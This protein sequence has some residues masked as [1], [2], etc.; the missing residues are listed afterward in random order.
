VTGSTFGWTAVPS[1]PTLSGFS[2]GNGN[3]IAQTLTNTGFTIETV[4]YTIIPSA[5]ACDGPPGNFVVTVNP[6]PDLSNDPASSQICSATSPEVILTSH[7]A[8]ATFTW[9]A[10][11]SSANITGY[12]PGSGLVIDQVLT[13][14]G[15]NV[16]TVT[17][18][19][20][21]TANGCPGIAKDY[22]VTI[23]SVPDVYFNPPAQAICNAETCNIQNL[24]T[25]TGTT[26]TWT[27][28]GSSAN[29]SGFSAGSGNLIAQ[30]LYNSGTTTET[31]TYSVA[32]TAFGC[33]A[34]P[35]QNLVVT[36][37]PKPAITSSVT[38]FSQC[39][40][41]TTGIV[42]AAGVANSTF[43]WVAGG[44]SPQVTGYAD[45]AGLIIQ[46]TLTNSGF[47][48][49]LV[50]YSVTPVANSCNGDPVDFTVTVYPVADVYFTPDGQTLCTGMT[51]NMTIAS[52]VAG[53]SFTWT[54]TGSS[55]QV[56]GYSGGSGTLIQQLLNNAGYNVESVTYQAFP[57][58]NGCAG[59]PHDVIVTVNPYPSVSFPVC[60][61]AVT[62]TDAQP[63]RLR[64][65]TPVNGTYSG[66][67]VTAGVFY[68]S[69]AGAGTFTLTYAY[70][71]T[72]GC[73]QA[74][75]QSITVISPLPVTCGSNFT[76]IR[77]NQSYPTVQ[78]GTQCWM[79]A[80]LNYGSSIPSTLMQRDNCQTEKYCFGDN[81]ANCLST[82]GLYQW[83]EL[84]RYDN[85]SGAQ[86]FCPP[87]WHIPTEA[88]WNTL[89]NF[90]ISSG[91]AGSPLK[92]TGYSGFNALLSGVRFNNISWNFDGFATILWS[93]T[94][95]SGTK[96]WAHG[97]NTYNPSVSFYPSARTNAFGVRCLKD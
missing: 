76:D 80:N 53:S 85:N 72:Y 27:A 24:S 18:H 19:V 50:T 16:E 86:G 3:S 20:D 61:D 56:S 28:S 1:A 63:I 7:V 45:G 81:A 42:P 71:N 57:T 33:P 37:Y 82:G 36:V 29:L 46:Q 30:T 39:S 70:T 44:S 91:F 89:F 17:Y 62:T 88:Q 2:D 38:T 8:G 49:E 96:A 41:A 67:G 69:L 43:T 25:V 78:I 58:A 65:G 15:L 77:D 95:R 35:P 9:T 60:F 68:P 13:N 31:V 10:T 34:G 84:M 64:G 75:G 11:G 74:A 59:T 22:L 93:S 48:P 92:S 83:D 12:G 21:P 52:H 14:L 73:S 90:Y 4:T 94:L 23:V 66:P 87:G 97:M 79:A 54:A 5:N 47:D 51:C 55:G 26:F 40:G 6:V 32:P